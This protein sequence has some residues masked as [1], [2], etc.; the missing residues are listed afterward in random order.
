MSILPLLGGTSLDSQQLPGYLCPGQRRIKTGRLLFAPGENN[1]SVRA[2]HWR[3]LDHFQC[4]LARS[5]VWT[6]FSS[7]ANP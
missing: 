7:T 2:V 1:E 3:V 6:F 4:T 5:V